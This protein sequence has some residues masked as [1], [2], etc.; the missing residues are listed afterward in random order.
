MKSFSSTKALLIASSLAVLAPAVNAISVSQHIIDV[1]T[2]EIFSPEMG[3]NP[4][5]VSLTS[6]D[7]IAETVQDGARNSYT[8]TSQRNEWL[9]YQED[10][11]LQ[12]FGGKESNLGDI[13][14]AQSSWTIPT[15]ISFS[16]DGTTVDSIRIYNHGKVEVVSSGGTI[17][18][19]ASVAPDH[20]DYRKNA[21]QYNL[22]SV[23]VNHPVILVTYEM[24]SHSNAS[25]S[26]QMKG[27]VRINTSLPSIGHRLNKSNFDDPLFNVTAGEFA[28]EIRHNGSY[29]H[30]W[31][32]PAGLKERSLTAPS[33]FENNTSNVCEI[34]GGEVI[35]GWYNNS[36]FDDPYLP[37]F[38][39]VQTEGTNTLEESGFLEL[40]NYTALV[41]Q[42]AIGDLGSG[43]SAWS[44]PQQFY[45][46][47]R[48]PDI[49]FTGNEYEVTYDGSPSFTIAPEA[50]ELFVSGYITNTA[51]VAIQ[52]VIYIGFSSYLTDLNPIISDVT[53]NGVEGSC[54]ATDNR[55]DAYQCEWPDTIEPGS[56]VSFSA[57]VYKTPGVAGDIALST[58][59]YCVDGTGSEYYCGFSPLYVQV[60]GP[61]ESDSSG[62]GSVFWL[63]LL[64]LPLLRL[65][66]TS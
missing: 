49:V 17:L 51:E 22:I 33:G 39:Y 55:N 26:W 44:T 52:P 35:L 29:Y 9:I 27:Q 8:V 37:E 66:R 20:M 6:S 25:S 19:W 32:T 2:P 57:T 4:E 65:R 64:A 41:R 53:I 34:S 14:T 59:I 28:C 45:T 40:Q 13:S 30:S 60:A 31:A 3:M 46:G 16:I 23:R 12:L 18:A 42:Q 15:P 63:T 24:E 48:G 58:D 5:S 36:A 47:S 43:F 54:A 62:G 38:R 61:S 50:G 10:V 7:L 21:Q 1:S 56:G 11:N